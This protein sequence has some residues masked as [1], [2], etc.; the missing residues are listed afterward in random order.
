MLHNLLS[1]FTE[2]P[3][4]SVRREWAGTNNIVRWICPEPDCNT[5]FGGIEPVCPCCAN[6][7]VMLIKPSTIKLKKQRIKKMKRSRA[8]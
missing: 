8:A 4:L 6:R 1:F 2:K 5:K 7:S 3:A